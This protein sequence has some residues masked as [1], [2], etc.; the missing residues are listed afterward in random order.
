MTSPNLKGDCLSRFEGRDSYKALV[1]GCGITGL[2]N[3]RGKAEH[4]VARAA[5]H[6]LA[7]GEKTG[8]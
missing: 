7:R 8:L 4:S 3:I 1:G 5:H 2:R 6:V